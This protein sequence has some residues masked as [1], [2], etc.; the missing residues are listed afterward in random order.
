ME[1]YDLGLAWNWEY[2][3]TFVQTLSQTFQKREL[4]LFEVGHHNVVEVLHA[5]Q[6]RELCWRAF[7]DRA[8]DSDGAFLPLVNWAERQPLFNLNEMAKARRAWNKATM[9]LEFITAGVHTPY[10]LVLDPYQ[11]HPQLPE[12]DLNVLGANFI[13]K[14]AHGGG[15][16]GVVTGAN[17]REQVAHVR[18][19]HPTD[20]Y[21]LQA[22]IAPAHIAGKP[23]WFRIIYCLGDQ[24]ICWWNT[25]THVYSLLTPTDQELIDL[26]AIRATM[27][28]I[29]AVCGLDLFSSEIALMPDGRLIA[30]DYI[31][32]PL[33]LRLQS[34][35][36]DGVPDSIIAAIAEKIAEAIATLRPEQ[37]LQNHRNFLLQL[38]NSIRQTKK[39]PFKSNP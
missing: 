10:T 2:D 23:A 34:S 19:Q 35:A 12:L 1:T 24:H 22:H 32:D 30:V 21:L 8:G 13:I 25:D 4:R 26:P 31:N 27:Q 20:H 16:E 15:G 14:P 17:S 18:Q 28:T 9:H 37:S 5:L 36:A 11:T 3:R 7:W 29:A 39:E 33:D 38:L 6:K